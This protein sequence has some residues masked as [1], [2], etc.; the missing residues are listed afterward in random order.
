MVKK[1][2]WEVQEEYTLSQS[3]PC[4]WLS[5]SAGGYYV[6]QMLALQGLSI[7]NKFLPLYLFTT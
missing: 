4:K 5:P 7:P 6:M 2:Q 3:C 1:C